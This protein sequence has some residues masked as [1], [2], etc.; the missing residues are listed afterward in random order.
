MKNQPSTKFIQIRGWSLTGTKQH[1]GVRGGITT[2]NTIRH[3]AYAYQ[4]WKSK[5]K[6]AMLLVKNQE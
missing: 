3:V 1:Q 4:D 2:E 5:A 6:D